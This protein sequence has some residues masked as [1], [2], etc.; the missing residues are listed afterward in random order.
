ME[1]TD[2][3]PRQRARYVAV[4]DPAAVEGYLDE[5]CQTMGDERLHLFSVVPMRREGNTVGLWLFFAR[6]STALEAER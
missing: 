2:L 6:P 5:L 1:R 3:H 4:E